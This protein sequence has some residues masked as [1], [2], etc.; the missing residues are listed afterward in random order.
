MGR[1]VAI[2]YGR[3]RAGIAVTDPMQIIA[4]GLTT[5]QAVKTIEF[6]DDYCKKEIVEAFVV[7]YARQMDHSDSES[8][9][10]IKPFVKKLTKHFPTIPVHMIDERFT[11][12]I[13]HQT[14]ID[15]GLK[16]KQRQN[17]ALVDT[18]SATLILQSYLEQK[19]TGYGAF[20]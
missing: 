4:N 10:Y 8:M 5:V 3:K 16:K 20:K 11:S 18:I 15:G 13:A 1:V 6:L 19:N 9:I 2:D 12:K 17:K 14:M 7:G